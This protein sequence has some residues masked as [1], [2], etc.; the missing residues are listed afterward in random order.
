MELF[1]WEDQYSLGIHHI[2]EQH[3]TLVKLINDLHR[4]LVN[5]TTNKIIEETLSSLID[6]TI[7][8]FNSEEEILKSH[9]YPDYQ[10][11]KK[12]H[13]ALAQ[14][15]LDIQSNIQNNS[16]ILSFEV[17]DFLVDWLINHI[18]TEDHK[19]G[20]FFKSK[21]IDIEKSSSQN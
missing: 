21:N 11:H 4:S 16:A 19:Y 7:Y 20:S 10:T 13:D 9:K 2:D 14:Q 3:K 1:K 15:V 18:L 12:Q 5:G 8:H 17:M 6:Y